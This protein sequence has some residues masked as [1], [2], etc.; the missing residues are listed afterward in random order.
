MTYLDFAPYWNVPRSIALRSLIPEI[1]KDPATLDRKDLEIVA[2]FGASARPLPPTPEN[3]AKLRAGE[4]QLRQRPG[5]HNALGLVKFI[6][7]NAHNV[8][9][10]STPQGGL[11]Q[12]S[13]R[14]FSSGCIRVKE[15]EALAE[16]VLRDEGD[17][18]REKIEAAMHGDQPQRVVLDEPHWVL[19]LY[20]TAMIG[21]GG[22]I[23]FYEDI[24]GHDAELAR[25]LAQGYP[26][27]E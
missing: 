1:E 26:Y 25:A 10:H 5:P 16:Y 17:W 22:R 11:F 3:I 13:R 15:P 9:L 14:T 24:Y 2:H 27:P 20:A 18:D 6:M 7:P 8:Y 4:L 19:I 12:R 21:E 23:Q